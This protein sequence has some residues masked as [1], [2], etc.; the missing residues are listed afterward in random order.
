MRVCAVARA[1]VQAVLVALAL[2]SS[3]PRVVSNSECR[4]T[5]ADVHAALGALAAAAAFNFRTQCRPS[6]AFGPSCRL[7]SACVGMSRPT[8]EAALVLLLAAAFALAAPCLGRQLK[9]APGAH[10][11]S[12]ALP[13]R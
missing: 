4:A 1:R 8:K 2:Y 11:L 13:G 5:G 12:K 9:G 10:L 6:H 7:H 3:L